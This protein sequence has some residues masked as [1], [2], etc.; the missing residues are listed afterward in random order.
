MLTLHDVLRAIVR[1]ESALLNDAK[2]VVSA[3]EAIS[4]HENAGTVTVPEPAPAPQDDAAP[5]DDA[6]RAEFEA[7]RAS[8]AAP[9]VQDGGP[10]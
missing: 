9:A 8:R 3:L 7:W 10:Q 5:A 1:G 2:W 6:E 4:T